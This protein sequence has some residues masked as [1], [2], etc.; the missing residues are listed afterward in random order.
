MFV[1]ILLIG[2]LVAASMA[3][4]KDGRLLHRAGL[5]GGCTQLATPAPDGGTWQACTRGK[6]EDYPNLAGKSCISFGFK[7]GREFWRCPAAVV[8]SQAP[9]A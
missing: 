4:V 8:S 2:V 7:R 6:L 5:V 9:R 1:K 3:V